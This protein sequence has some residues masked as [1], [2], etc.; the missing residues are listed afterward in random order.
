MW[1]EIT[2]A[3]YQ[4]KE[5]RYSSD[6]TEAEWAVIGPLLPTARPLGRPRTTDLREVVNAILYIST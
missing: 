6:L 1:T 5:L 4:R 2:R 3:Q